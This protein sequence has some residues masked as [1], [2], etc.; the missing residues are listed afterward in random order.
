MWQTVDALWICRFP[1]V[2]ARALAIGKILYILREASALF[3]RSTIPGNSRASTSG[4]SNKLG[5]HAFFVM[6]R[7]VSR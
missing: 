1:I 3:A 5:S 7:I 2:N 4:T 6:V